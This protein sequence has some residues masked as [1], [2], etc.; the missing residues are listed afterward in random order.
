M[1]VPT[2]S[3]KGLAE[4]EIGGF[5][6]ALLSYDAKNELERLT[7]RHFDAV[8]FP[9]LSLFR[10]DDFLE[11]GRGPHEAHKYRGGG[12]A[13]YQHLQA[14]IEGQSNDHTFISPL[15]EGRTIHFQSDVD[16]ADYLKQIDQ[17]RQEIVE[18]NV[19]EMNYC[20]TYS[21]DT[22][23]DPF[24]LFRLMQTHAPAPFSGLVKLGGKYVVCG[25]MERFLAKTGN[26]LV[27][28]PIK[29]TRANKGQEAQ[30]RH[31]L[32][33]SEKERAENLMIVDL[34]RN[35]LHRCCLP[36]TVEVDELFGIYSYSAVHQMI[37]TVSGQLRPGL[38][39]YDVIKYM[40]PMGS[41]TGAP[42]ISAM[43]LIEKFERFKR[44]A[45]S[46]SIG[47]V[48]EQGDFDFN[49]VIRSVLYDSDTGVVS[50][51]VGSALTIDSI[52]GDELDECNAKIEKIKELVSRSVL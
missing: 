37:S 33:Q 44:G 7:S 24:F 11:M 2:P 14:A 50:I 21:A 31:D 36:G 40:F 12:Q 42:K 22:R 34:V 5:H 25:S 6:F 51:P 47:Y 46:G 10:P 9:N 45:Y 32:L 38:G 27:S 13:L 52:P 4:L 3:L 16:D 26:R 48:N 19:Y 15:I 17:I 8:P 30:E 43:Q 49:V 18:G 35:D 1:D 41:M 23:I 20:R 29:G 39:L 28:Q